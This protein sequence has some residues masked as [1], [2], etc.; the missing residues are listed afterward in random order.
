MDTI[1]GIR[2][3]LIL[4]TFLFYRFLHSVTTL[5]VLWGYS[6]SNFAIV[7]PSQSTWF[8]LNVGI[9]NWIYSSIQNNVRNF[10]IERLNIK[11]LY[12]ILWLGGKWFRVLL[13]LWI[14]NLK[15]V[16]WTFSTWTL[17]EWS[18]SAARL[19]VLLVICTYGMELVRYH[20]CRIEK[21]VSQI[22]YILWLRKETSWSQLTKNC[23]L[24]KSIFFC[25]WS[26]HRNSI[27]SIFYYTQKKTWNWKIREINSD[28]Q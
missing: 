12:L 5:T 28:A 2:C 17:R 15:H 20:F 16:T 19:Y 25:Q 26:Q 27:N 18:T 23:H 9:F 21:I 3:P 22:F 10:T 13:S 7:I 24:T 11:K 6:S 8:C 1:W 14:F 4:L